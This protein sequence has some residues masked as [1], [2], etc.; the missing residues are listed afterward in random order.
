MYREWVNFQENWQTNPERE[1]REEAKGRIDEKET[2]EEN[3]V[4]K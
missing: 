2:E 3:A 1:R 4:S